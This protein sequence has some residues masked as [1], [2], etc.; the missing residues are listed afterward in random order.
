MKTSKEI[1]N[2]LL[3]AVSEI[4]KTEEDCFNMVDNYLESYYKDTAGD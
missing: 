1:L 2:F 4:V 3:H